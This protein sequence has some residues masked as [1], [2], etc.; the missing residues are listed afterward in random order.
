MGRSLIILFAALLTPELVADPALGIQQPDGDVPTMQAIDSGG[1]QVVVTESK[2]SATSGEPSAI[3]GAGESSTA[4][5]QNIASTLFSNPL[6]YMLIFLLAF[7]VLL[8]IPQQRAIRRQ[9]KEKT[10]RLTSLKKNDRIVT[11]S[12][13][14]AVVTNINSEAGTIT[15]RIDENSNAKLTINRD[16][17][18]TV[19]KGA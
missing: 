4:S 16:T 6:S 1:S 11:A 10:D 15:V 13:I 9:Q 8:I 17:V 2:P 14:H 12:G 5:A 7:Y 18:Q 19:L 3:W